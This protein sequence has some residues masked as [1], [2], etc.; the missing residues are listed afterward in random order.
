LMKPRFSKVLQNVTLTSGITLTI[1]Y[2]CNHLVSSTIGLFQCI[3]SAC[4]YE[5]R[6]QMFSLNLSLFTDENTLIFIQ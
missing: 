2:S 5:S 1:A 4:R 3:F 6:Y